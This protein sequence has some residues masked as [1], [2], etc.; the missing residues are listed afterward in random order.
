VALPNSETLPHWRH[1]SLVW[2]SEIA[3]IRLKP[4][5]RPANWQF[6]YR[7]LFDEPF[8]GV[9]VQNTTSRLQ[10]IRRQYGEIADL[11]PEAVVDHLR[12]F[13][14][15]FAKRCAAGTMDV[16]GIE[17]L[18]AEFEAANRGNDGVTYE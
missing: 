14:Q 2:L 11:Q 9:E 16:A 17:Q 8:G 15:N 10:L 12:T 6:Y 7:I 3:A 18:I 13:H 4:T 1:E 5:N